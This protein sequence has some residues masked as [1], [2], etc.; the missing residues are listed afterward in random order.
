VLRI[1]KSGE[2]L[3]ANNAAKPLL[4]ALG[5]MVGD[6]APYEWVGWVLEAHASSLLKDEEV[7][8]GD[9][10]FSV[11]I[12]PV[13][14][15]D[16]IYCKDITEQ[17]K[18]E[19]ELQTSELRFRQFFENEPNYCYM[20]SDEGKI[21]DI[22]KSALEALGYEKEEVIGKSFLSTIYSSSSY[23]KA[24]R[25]FEKWKV[26]GELKDEE[27]KIIT[28]AGEERTVLLSVSAIKNFNGRPIISISVQRDITDWRMTEEAL[29]I[30][31]SKYRSLFENQ[32]DVDLE[33]I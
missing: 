4:E 21:L 2:V 3:Y 31:E 26:S 17:K 23:E 6:V 33:K 22:N 1:S 20:I 13:A 8:F 18:V 29:G 14:D 12:V 5:S 27:L 19:E 11:S 25:L 24:Q 9:R 30:I 7:I 15:K 32:L 16:Y 10:V 28:K